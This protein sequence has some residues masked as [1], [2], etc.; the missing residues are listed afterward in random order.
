MRKCARIFSST[1]FAN[2]SLDFFVTEPV[3][4]VKGLEDDPGIGLEDDIGLEDESDFGELGSDESEGKDWSDLEREAAEDDDD[5]ED[6][7]GKIWPKIS[8]NGKESSKIPDFVKETNFRNA[9]IHSCKNFAAST[10][11]ARVRFNAS[12]HFFSALKF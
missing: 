10:S 2:E 7:R 1:L 12:A 5:D 4:L 11:H 8:Q 6:D 3:F 9:H